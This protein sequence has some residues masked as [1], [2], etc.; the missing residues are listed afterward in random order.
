MIWEL[1]DFTHDEH[2][3]L[4]WLRKTEPVREEGYMTTL[5]G[6]DA[7]RLIESH[8]TP[9]PLYFYL[10]INAPRTPYQAP[11][12]VHRKILKHPRSHRIR[13]GSSHGGHGTTSGRRRHRARRQ[14]TCPGRTWQR[15]F[16][17]PAR[18]YIRPCSRSLRWWGWRAARAHIRGLYFRRGMSGELQGL[19]S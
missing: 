10:T 11:Q 4:D 7:A 3:G 8:D 12:E 18:R 13:T 19:R 14:P 16:P 17:Q 1:D 15:P 5:I 6:Q 9:V 2:G